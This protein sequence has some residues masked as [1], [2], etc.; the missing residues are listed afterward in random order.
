MTGKCFDCRG[1][2]RG[3]KHTATIT[4]N[5]VFCRIK[6]CMAGPRLIEGV[7]LGCTCTFG[8]K[9]RTVIS[10]VALARSWYRITRPGDSLIL[11]YSCGSAGS[12][13]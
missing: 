4:A 12:I 5:E 10:N 6:L 3:G 2:R 11:V 1:S 8:S 7:F 9:T 13:D